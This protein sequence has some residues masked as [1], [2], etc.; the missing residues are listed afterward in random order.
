MV[1]WLNAADLGSNP[2]QGTKIPHAM[3]PKNRKQNQNQETT[4]KY[5]LSVIWWASEG[6]EV[7]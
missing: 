3:R 6:R 7:P 4:T 1:Q 5:T 2:S